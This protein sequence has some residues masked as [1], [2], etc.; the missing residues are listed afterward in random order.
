MG[1]VEAEEVL[2]ILCFADDTILFWQ[3][4]IQEAEEV[5]SILN[6][7]ATALGLIINLEKSTM[8]FSLNSSKAVIEAIQ[9]ILAIPVV[10]KFE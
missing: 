5:L 9:Q 3:A 7:Y 4:T 1:F 6:K 8:I 2:S 10:E